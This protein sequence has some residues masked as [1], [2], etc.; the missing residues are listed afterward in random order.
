[1]VLCANLLR[2]L[3]QDLPLSG[4]C[5]FIFSKKA[6]IIWTLPDYTIP[7]KEKHIHTIPIH[8]L[9]CAALGSALQPHAFCWT[10]QNCQRLFPRTSS[11]LDPDYWLQFHSCT[12]VIFLIP[13]NGLSLLSFGIVHATSKRHS[14][15]GYKTSCQACPGVLQDP[16]FQN[17]YVPN[18]LLWQIS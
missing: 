5:F 13:G 8:Q 12:L 4:P 16:E 11:S 7:E 17:D 2:C 1:M 14:G 6:I 10:E 9:E 3:G 15:V 18:M